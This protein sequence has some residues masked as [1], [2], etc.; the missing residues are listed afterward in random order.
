MGSVAEEVFENWE[1]D[2]VFSSVRVSESM[3][4]KT[5]ETRTFVIYRI[6]IRFFA[7]L[8]FGWRAI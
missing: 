2:I 5:V 8:I 7:R 3:N 1:V 4:W 6:W